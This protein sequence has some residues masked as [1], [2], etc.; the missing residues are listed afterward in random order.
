MGRWFFLLFTTNK[1]HPGF[2][3][4]GGPKYLHVF[5]MIGGLNV[6]FLLYNRIMVSKDIIYIKTTIEIKGDL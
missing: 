3:P 1:F 5:F 4:V 6:E 2:G